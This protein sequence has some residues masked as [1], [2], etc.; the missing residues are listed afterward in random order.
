MADRVFIKAGRLLDGTGAPPREDVTVIV[1]DGKIAAVERVLPDP[2]PEGAEIID[3]T[4][5]TVLP[6]LVD[7]HVHL[8]FSGSADP[9]ADV[10]RE[11][12]EQLLLRAAANAQAALVSGVTALRD[13]G[14][15]G[16]LTLALR[17]AINAGTLVG[18]RLYAAGPPIT[19]TAGHLH[20]CGLEVEGPERLRRA[21]RDL[22]KER[23]DFV[24]IMVTGGYMTPRTNPF[25]LQYTP[26]ELAAVVEDSHRLGHRVA[27]HIASKDGIRAAVEAGLDTFEHCVWHEAS[28]PGEYRYDEELGAAMAARGVIVGLTI[29]AG[30]RRL[31]AAVATGEELP[32]NVRS[33]LEALARVHAQMRAQGVRLAGHSDAGTVH[34]TFDGL[35]QS[36][37]ALVRLYGWSPMEAVVSMTRTAAEA[38]GIAAEVGTVEPGKAADLIV[39]EGDPRCEPEALQRVD[40]VILKGR[41]VARRG[42]LMVGR[43]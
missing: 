10:L 29:G 12:D 17:E 20:F 40:R 22:H 38:T 39:V 36:A 13:C 2:V 35:A 33:R 3:A 8:C 9:L 27:G 6:G 4:D 34:C 31:A 23:V 28:A 18:P 14:S 30:E 43:S 26:E 11:T 32:A 19:T 16:F 24:K 15:R 37:A 21:V 41:T 25:A 5:R 1:E 42:Q 7:S